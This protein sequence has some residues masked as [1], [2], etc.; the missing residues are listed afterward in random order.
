MSNTY[1][2]KPRQKTGKQI[3]RHDSTRKQRYE[4]LLNEIVRLGAVG[5]VF[6]C[7]NPL[8]VYRPT[9]LFS[10]GDFESKKL[11]DIN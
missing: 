1:C 11:F 3:E 5:V 6:F 10:L 7:E 2:T 4:M 8:R 9:G